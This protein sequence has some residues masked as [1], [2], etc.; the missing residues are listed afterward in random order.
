MQGRAKATYFFP[1]TSIFKK[2]SCMQERQKRPGK[3]KTE[4]FTL[5]FI[6]NAKLK[7]F[8]FSVYL[9]WNI[10]QQN[11]TRKCISRENRKKR[12]KT[13]KSSVTKRQTR[14]SVRACRSS[15][16]HCA[17][18]H[19]C[20]QRWLVYHC[21]RCLSAL[22]KM[23]S[24]G[25]STRC[26]FSEGWG[27]GCQAFRKHANCNVLVFVTSLVRGWNFRAKK[28]IH[29]T[30]EPEVCFATW[31]R[32]RQNC[33]CKLS[34]KTKIPFTSKHSSFVNTVRIIFSINTCQ[35]DWTSC[36]FLVCPLNVLA[37]SN[38][39]NNFCVKL[40]YIVESSEIY[41]SE[42]SCARV[43]LFSCLFLQNVNMKSR[44]PCFSQSTSTIR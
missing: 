28:C 17:F 37:F 14:Y 42:I 1:S 18:H 11:V 10:L 3:Q 21:E 7:T 35:Y 33:E 19:A 30:S 43:R 16:R 27:P 40:A 5:P 44:Q 34:V 23:T 29:R 12:E 13:D 15:A 26:M 36:L 38:D 41:R 8:L 31:L 4:C 6:G 24:I 22:R 32:E 20:T 2:T 39:Q 25:F 9:S